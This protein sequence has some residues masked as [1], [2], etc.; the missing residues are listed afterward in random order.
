MDAVLKTLPMGGVGPAGQRVS[1]VE[2][3]KAALVGG[4]E[5]GI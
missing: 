5:L 3:K 2:V 4:S 1:W